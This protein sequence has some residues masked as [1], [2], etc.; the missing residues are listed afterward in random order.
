[1]T[2]RNGIAARAS[3]LAT[4]LA[5]TLAA[6]LALGA[7][8]AAAEPWRAAGENRIAV[9]AVEGPTPEAELFVACVGSI[10]TAGVLMPGEQFVGRVAVRYRFDTGPAASDTWQAGSDPQVI[11]LVGRAAVAPFLARLSGSSEFTIASRASDQ[12][13]ARFEVAGAAK[14]AAPVLEV[15]KGSP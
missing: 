7:P 9:R 2:V 14:A 4:T 15:C 6:T 3:V 5:G 11:Q 8:N 10:L 13:E 12:A 1:M